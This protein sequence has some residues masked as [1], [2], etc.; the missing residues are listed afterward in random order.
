MTS[1]E[2]DDGKQGQRVTSTVTTTEAVADG[3]RPRRTGGRDL[4]H[5]WDSWGMTACLAVL[6][7]FAAA[8]DPEFLQLANIQSVLTESA[9][10]GI[11]AA[12]MTV[13]I[14]NGTFDLSVG[15]QLALVSVVSLMGY[16]AGG[17]GLAVAAALGCGLACGLV[18]GTLVTLL[19]VPPFVA[20]LGMLFVFR[21]VAYILTE[22]SPAVLPY[23]EIDS[24]FAQLGS[25]R[26][27]EVPLP[28][29][30]MV[31]FFA[32][33]YVF[34]RRTTAGRRVVAYGSS[35]EAARFS[36]V[37]ATRVRFLVFGLLG[38]AVGIA[39]LTYI[40]RIWT[41]DG[42]TQD[43]FELRVITAAVLGGASLQGGKG[44]LVGTFSA[45]LL[46][47]VLNDLMVGQGV[48]AGVQ[49]MVL[50]GVL[51]LALGIDGVRTKYGHRFRAVLSRRREVAAPS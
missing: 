31:G 23:T 26:I 4:G 50:G 28:F 41:A 46:V 47:A 10:L 35:P 11:V 15:G 7:A 12:A 2:L 51:I 33:T 49:Q 27:A 38:L 30:L 18:N 42:A 24:G 34:L 16:E 29:L 32:A 48:S 20:T 9:Y 25:M 5:L 14:V 3:G 1:T 37:S 40:T 13:A 43:G 8:T 45:V 19:R 39:V 21:G 36:G 22:D 17:T 44:S 6:V